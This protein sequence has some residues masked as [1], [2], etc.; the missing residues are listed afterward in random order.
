ME[1][2]NLTFEQECDIIE[3]MGWVV[4]CHSPFEIRH[5]EDG[6]SFA[7]GLAATYLKDALIE[8]YDPEDM[9]EYLYEVRV[10]TKMGFIPLEIERVSD[11][12]LLYLNEPYVD[13]VHTYSFKIEG[14][15]NTMNYAWE[16]GMK[17]Y[18]PL[19]FRVISWTKPKN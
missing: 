17:L 16:E 14:M 8:E 3:K 13:G 9:E 6:R 1:S 10:Q 15:P 2:H 11:G 7:S 12:L 4:E 19:D 5:A 18:D